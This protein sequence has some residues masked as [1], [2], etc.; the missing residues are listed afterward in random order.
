MKTS[1]I[2]S[3][4]SSTNDRQN[5]ERQVN[6]L[7][8]F[9]QKNDFNIIR[10]FSENISGAKK[11][12]ERSGLTECVT[13][14]IEN[15]ID[16][17][18]C[19]ELSRIGRDT[20]QVLKTLETLHDNK[21][22]VYIQ[23]IGINTLNEKKEINPMASI[24]V[25]VMAEM[26]KIERTGIVYR[27]NSGRE[28]YIQRGGKLGRTKGSKKPLEAKKEEYKLVLSLL[29]RGTSIRNAAKLANTSIS[30]VQRL[31]KEFGI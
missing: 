16:T 29:K 3:R 9:A 17:L 21:V 19:S 15:K 11:N 27:L 22:N 23:N 12:E 10:E 26:S 25:T 6:D 24:I 7:R 2:F 5:T 14:C 8:S 18:L 13:F 30:T 4:V 28:N 20:L 31:K 1:V